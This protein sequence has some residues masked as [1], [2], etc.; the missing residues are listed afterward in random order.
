MNKKAFFFI[1]TLAISFY[2]F[3]NEVLLK[4]AR[5]HT[6]TELGTLENSDIHIRNG[7]I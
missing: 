3:S 4:N 2:S 1:I 5:V 7:L 6:A